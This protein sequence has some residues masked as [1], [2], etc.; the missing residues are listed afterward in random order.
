M[1]DLMVQSEIMMLLI[2]VMYELVEKFM[3]QL[4]IKLNDGLIYHHYRN[5]FVLVH[6]DR[7]LPPCS[8][9]ISLKK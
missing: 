3:F 8:F 6:V 1:K 2:A 9:A 7:K 4:F 5:C